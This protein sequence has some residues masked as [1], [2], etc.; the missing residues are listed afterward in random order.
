[1]KP[2]VGSRGWPRKLD[3]RPVSQVP[4]GLRQTL[5]PLNPWPALWT[6]AVC[7]HSSAAGF[8][9]HLTFSSTSTACPGPPPVARKQPGRYLLLV[10]R[11]PKREPNCTA[12]KNAAIN[13][14]RQWEWGSRTLSDFKWSSSSCHLIEA[15]YFWSS[16]LLMTKYKRLL[17]RW[18]TLPP[19]LR[20]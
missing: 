20:Q 3:R 4:A 8:Q 12:R 16:H 5:L 1:M 2:C 10:G 19:A 6:S 17:L 18:K 15:S 11:E 13:K 14:A 9:S 7:G